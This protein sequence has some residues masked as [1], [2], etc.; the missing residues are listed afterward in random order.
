MQ[1][2]IVK[3]HSLEYSNV[4]NLSGRLIVRLGEH[5]YAATLPPRSAGRNYLAADLFLHPYRSLQI[6]LARRAAHG[7][8][9]AYRELGVVRNAYACCAPRHPAEVRTAGVGSRSN[10]SSQP[11][12]HHSVACPRGACLSGLRD[13]GRVGNERRPLSCRTGLPHW[14]ARNAVANIRR[15]DIYEQIIKKLNK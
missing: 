6:R 10:G 8:R 1:T 2:T 14:R 9:F 11:A 13:F 12:C 15:L 7:H 5:H 4:K 3:L